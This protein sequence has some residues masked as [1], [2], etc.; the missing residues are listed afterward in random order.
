MIGPSTLVFIDTNLW[1][2]ST[3]LQS[4]AAAQPLHPSSS[5]PGPGTA[6]VGVFSPPESA[7][8][9]SPRPL[10]PSDR[11]TLSSVGSTISPTPVVHARR[12]FFAL[13]EWQTAAT[14]G[15]LNCTLATSSTTT[16]DGRGTLFGGR[17][18]CDVVFATGHRLV[19]VKGGFDFYENV[20][21]SQA[22]STDGGQYVWNLVSES[23]DRRQLAR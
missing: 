8:K 10:P 5:I 20:S 12:H 2:C 14:G 22:S 9:P 4:I 17:G 1:V 21:A 16:Q 3:E 11:D 15:R 18:S 19:I 7:R 6:K 13:S 23:M